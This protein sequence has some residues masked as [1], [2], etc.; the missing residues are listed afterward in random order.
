LATVRG[1]DDD[2]DVRAVLVSV[3]SRRAYTVLSGTSGAQALEVA[4][5][6]GAPIDLLVTDVAMPEMDGIELA[7]ELRKKNPTAAVL[8]ISG[9]TENADLLSA[10]LGPS[11]HCL[12]KPFIPGGLTPLV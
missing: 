4:R 2:D 11:T 5:R 7:A 10:P 9:Y 1:C 6:H 8:Y 12:A 3:L